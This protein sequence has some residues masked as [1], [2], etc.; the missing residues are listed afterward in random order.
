M[1]P[2][3]AATGI[4]L[5]VALGLPAP[6]AAQGAGSVRVY[7]DSFG[8][9]I[10]DRP[11]GPKRIVVGQGGSARQYANYSGPANSG[12]ANSGPAAPQAGNPDQ[13]GGG[14]GPYCYSPP[15]LVWGRS[16]MYGF[17]EGVIPQIGMVC[18]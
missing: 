10:F 13:Q 15:V 4:A 8:N 1:R 17:H 14:A 11:G 6:A 3:T 5:T 7:A 16:Y 2:L 9:L 12:P 18:R